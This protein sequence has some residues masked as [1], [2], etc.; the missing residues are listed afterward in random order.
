M[1]KGRVREKYEASWDFSQTSASKANT[2]PGRL[3][4]QRH[5]IYITNLPLTAAATLWVIITT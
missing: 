2:I 3:S 4:G 1:K 5:S